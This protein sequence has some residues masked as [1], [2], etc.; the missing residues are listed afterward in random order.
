MSRLAWATATPEMRS[1]LQAFFR[2]EIGT[3]FYL[4][5]GTA[6]ALELGHRTSVDLDL[7][8]PGED[9]PSVRAALE[10]SLA[11]FSP[12]LADA[13]WG[14]LV[15]LANG[16][17]VGFYG[18]GYGLV[19]PLVEAEGVRLASIPDIG[20]MK[21]DAL[22]GRAKRRDFYDL[23]FICQRIPLRRLLDLG[24][25]KYPNVRDFEVQATKRLAYFDI[26]DPEP[27]PILL[28]PIDWETV[29]DFFGRQAKEI[30]RGWMR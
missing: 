1:L 18:Y 21:L 14:N 3:E 12:I 25:Q 9:I 13:S 5:G 29:K 30:G 24:P 4:A 22:L 28:E 27:D 23:Y 11:A 19:E 7:F 20:L 8:S 26:A 6:L 16:V 10:R 17:R 15:L 2:S